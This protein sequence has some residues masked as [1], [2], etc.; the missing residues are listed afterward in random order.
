LRV[1][2]PIAA[3][4]C[5]LGKLT[6]DEAVNAAHAALNRGVYSDALGAVTFAE[7]LWAEVGPLF[8]RAL[9]E[10]G[11]G[12]PDRAV[13][14]RRLARDFARR[15]VSGEL[16]PYDG[17]WAIWHELAWE[18]ETGDTLLPFIGL[19]SEW[20]DRPEFR[21]EYEA[22]IL[23]EARTLAE[24]PNAEQ[25]TAAGAEGTTVFPEV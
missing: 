18:P 9:D 7:P 17:A 16:P 10:L 5:A 24:A 12:V 23:R 4:W 13:A 6:T 2:L 14:V 25:G 19:A 11:V 15:I 8:R 22:D 3:A 20:E 1:E 21:R